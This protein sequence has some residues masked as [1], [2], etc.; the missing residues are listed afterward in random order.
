MG[1]SS[2]K[3]PSV[4]LIPPQ[5]HPQTLGTNEVLLGLET[6]RRNRAAEG[7]GMDSTIETSGR[8]LVDKPTTAK[9]TLLGQ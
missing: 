4:P 2:P 8:G 1:I 7:G 9:A 6:A 3:P 5:A